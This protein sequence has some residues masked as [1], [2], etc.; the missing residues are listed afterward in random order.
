MTRRPSRERGY[1]EGRQAYSA[2]ARVRD[3]PYDA[4]AYPYTD[5]GLA[6]DGWYDGFRFEWV[7]AGCPAERWPD[8]ANTHEAIIRR[9][10]DTPA[11]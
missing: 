11:C 9:R 2:G 1:A 5:E 8:A 4:A 3:N 10:E 6:R 7:Q